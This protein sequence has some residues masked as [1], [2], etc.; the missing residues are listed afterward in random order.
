MGCS[1]SSPDGEMDTDDD[2]DKGVILFIGDRGIGKTSLIERY[3]DKQFTPGSPKSQG[4]ESREISTNI[5]DPRKQDG[6]IPIIIEIKDP[7]VL[8]AS[9]YRIARGYIYA[10]DCTNQESFNYLNQYFTKIQKIRSEA[11]RPKALAA[12]KCDSQNHTVS[13]EDVQKWIDSKSTTN[14]KYPFI[15]KKTSAKDGTGVDDLFNEMID[16]IKA[17]FREG[18]QND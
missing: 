18:Y 15:F 3:C 13:D 11:D 17:Q 12:L 6:K 10:Y 5:S 16:Q 7:K 8:N 2:V 9:H 4:S 14:Q 1:G